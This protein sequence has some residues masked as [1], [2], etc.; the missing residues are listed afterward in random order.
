MDVAEQALQCVCACFRHNCPIRCVQVL[1]GIRVAHVREFSPNGHAVRVSAMHLIRERPW[2][3]GEM[4]N[5]LIRCGLAQ[6]VSVCLQNKICQLDLRKN[7]CAVCPSMTPKQ[8]RNPKCTGRRPI[9]RCKSGSCQK[10]VMREASSTFAPG[11]SSWSVS[12]LSTF[13]CELRR[14]WDLVPYMVQPSNGDRNSACFVEVGW[15]IRE[16][17]VAR[18]FTVTLPNY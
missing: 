14:A 10:Q 12:L 13:R 9:L 7:S 2:H 1:N 6:C 11:S 4:K 8:S 15:A 5:K 17:Q 16:Q 18:A 3:C